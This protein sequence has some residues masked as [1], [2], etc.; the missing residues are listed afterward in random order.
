MAAFD[1]LTVVLNRLVL[2]LGADASAPSWDLADTLLVVK[3]AIGV[4]AGGVGAL[5]VT[6]VS[7]PS[8]PG[9]R[10]AS[11]TTGTAGSG[12]SP[13]VSLPSLPGGRGR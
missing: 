5:A 8:T 4:L 3:V 11:S 6:G 12:G 1:G 10:R 7:R 9:T 2:V 13:P